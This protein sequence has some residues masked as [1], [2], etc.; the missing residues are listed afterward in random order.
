MK[1]ET[2]TTKEERRKDELLEIIGEKIIKKYGWKCDADRA[3]TS[4]LIERHHWLPSEIQKMTNAEKLLCLEFL[5][6]SLEPTIDDCNSV[7]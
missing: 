3:V 1:N 6:E 5:F 7:K 4:F 2:T